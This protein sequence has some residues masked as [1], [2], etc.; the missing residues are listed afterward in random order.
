[1]VQPAAAQFLPLLAAIQQFDRQ[2]GEIF[3]AHGSLPL[4]VFHKPE[5]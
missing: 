4:R 1:M 2:I 5:P 3:R